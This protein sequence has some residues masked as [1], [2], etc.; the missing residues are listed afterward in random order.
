MVIES[1]SATLVVYIIPWISCLVEVKLL[2]VSHPDHIKVE[3]KNNLVFLVNLME[4]VGVTVGRDRVSWRQM[5]CRGD[6][7]REQTK[8]KEEVLFHVLIISSWNIW[9]FNNIASFFAI[10]STSGRWH[11]L[12]AIHKAFSSKHYQYICDLWVQRTGARLSN[13]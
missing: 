1:H 11:K 10:F 3:T 4:M 6:P 9:G 2:R 12:V 13:Q 8:D 7:W 5:I